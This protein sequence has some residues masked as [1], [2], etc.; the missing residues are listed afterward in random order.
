MRVAFAEIAS[1]RTH[2]NAAKAHVGVIADALCSLVGAGCQNNGATEV[3]GIAMV[4]ERDDSLERLAQVRATTQKRDVRGKPGNMFQR[5]V[6]EFRV[7]VKNA[8][9]KRQNT[10]AEIQVILVV[11]TIKRHGYS[12]CLNL[13][14]KK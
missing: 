14:P 7:I 1:C 10:V 3:Q 4:R 13:Y 9:D 6:T 8:A 5:I 2:G 11:Y 12:F